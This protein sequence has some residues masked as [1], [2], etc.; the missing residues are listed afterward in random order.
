MIVWGKMMLRSTAETSRL[1]LT[2]ELRAVEG[3]TIQKKS[4]G[5]FPADR[6]RFPPVDDVVKVL[7]RIASQ[8]FAA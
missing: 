7:D 8:V 3:M 5:L 1:Y 6:K 2:A 4:T